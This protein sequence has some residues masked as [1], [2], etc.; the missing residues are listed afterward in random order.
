MSY[1]RGIF[2]RCLLLIYYFLTR[3][4]L[5][6]AP[7]AALP[8][9]LL[10]LSFALRRFLRYFD[11]RHYAS[12]SRRSGRR[13]HYREPLFVRASFGHRLH[14]LHSTLSIISACE[15]PKTFYHLY[16][17]RFGLISRERSFIFPLFYD[18]F[19]RHDTPTTANIYYVSIHCHA[20]A[21]LSSKF[22]VI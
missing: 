22:L 16:R 1:C 14:S 13:R 5:R 10:M 18:D 6:T 9:W 15:S 12:I 3:Y 20:T 21:S 8:R 17:R 4:K 2:T 19:T 11:D 7:T